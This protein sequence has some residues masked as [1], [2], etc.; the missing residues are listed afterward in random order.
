MDKKSLESWLK[1]TQ[2]LKDHADWCFLDD[3][4]IEQLNSDVITLKKELTARY[5]THIKDLVR[6]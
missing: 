2:W 4:D 6:G 1:H 3:H 5:G